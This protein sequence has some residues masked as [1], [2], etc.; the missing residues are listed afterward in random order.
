MS[1]NSA[2]HRSKAHRD[3]VEL[4]AGHLEQKHIPHIRSLSLNL[5]L[6]TLGVFNGV[7]K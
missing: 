5:F 4:C 2:L 7:A 6:W 1:R 3:D